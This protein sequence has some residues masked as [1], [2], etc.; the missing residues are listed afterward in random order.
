[1]NIKALRKVM[2]LIFG[3]LLLGQIQEVFPQKVP[4]EPVR[5]G[6]GPTLYTEKTVY[7]FGDEVRMNASGFKPFELV[8]L[9]VRRTDES[10]LVSGAI[11]EWPVIA[12]EKGS[13]TSIWTVTY[14]GA[15]F[16][17]EAV[18]T[19]SKAS[20]E[21]VFIVATHTA[22]LD[23]CRNGTLAS[24]ETCAG[25]NWVNGDLNASQAHFV[26]GQSV[27]YRLLLSNLSLGIH[28]ITIEW[29]T[30]LSG[31]HALD[32]LT[33]YD[34]TETTAD[35]CSDISGC[36]PAMYNTRAIP[37]DPEVAKGP[38]GLLG[39]ADD[40]TQ[41]P[42]VFTLYHGTMT[43][44]SGYTIDGTFAD[45]SKTRVT[46][47]FTAT[48][49]SV[50]LAWGAHIATRQDWGVDYSAIAISGA[51]Y[52]TRV[53]DFD[54]EGGGNQDRSVQ[55]GAVYFPGRI[56]IIKDAQ[57]N[58]AMAFNFT[59]VGPSVFN[60][61]LDDDGDNTNTYSNTQVFDQLTNFG[62]GDAVT[63]TEGASDG[64]WYLTQINCTS[65]PNGGSGTN[66]NVTSIQG[67]WVEI[68][69][70]EGEFVTCTFVNAV[71]TA[72]PVS[73]AGRVMDAN[74]SGIANAR[75]ILTK[76]SSGERIQRITN[77]LGYY[78]FVDVGGGEIYVISVS[79]KGF[80]FNPDAL[81]LTADTNLADVNFHA[82][83][84]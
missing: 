20:T 11:A 8:V 77:P 57:P 70:E 42:G 40:I 60:F 47:T 58:T 32:Y 81:V 33:S 78:R 62:T 16:T 50:I 14:P 34:R 31:R 61:I 37:I 13:F 43:A 53:W 83:P 4:L 46:I 55:S 82:M 69:L 72:A 27:P 84:R 38:D 49:S 51:P 52:H 10:A 15:E 68:V 39:T 59:A 44:V 24:P 1:M 63:V 17:I 79:A 5:S 23:Q 29:D 67:Q 54:G 28:T 48:S 76:A 2:F 19:G 30:T 80:E 56:T 6:S 71:V 3:V 7:N 65:D 25:A 73:I 64:F 36:N 35:P 22:D 9:A 21:V 18:G 74:G 41:A 12:D 66:N 26:E 75:L 45:T